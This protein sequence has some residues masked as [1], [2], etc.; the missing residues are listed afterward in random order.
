MNE[1]MTATVNDEKEKF[2]EQFE[3]AIYRKEIATVVRVSRQKVSRVL[4]D[5]L[6][7]D[8]KDA[9]NRR[10]LGKFADYWFGE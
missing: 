1:S 7:I 2:L 9:L 4:R 3:Y 10:E 8:H 6:G 5:K